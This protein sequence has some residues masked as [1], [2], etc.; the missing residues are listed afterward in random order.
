MA[1]KLQQQNFNKVHW[2]L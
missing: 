1:E 2:E